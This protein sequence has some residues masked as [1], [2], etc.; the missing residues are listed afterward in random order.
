MRATWLVSDG[1]PQSDATHIQV[2]D[3]DAIQP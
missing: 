1:Q 3:F 2:A